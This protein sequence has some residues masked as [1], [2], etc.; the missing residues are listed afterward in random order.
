MIEERIIVRVAKDQFNVIVGHVL[1][2]EPLSRAEADRLAHSQTRSQKVMQVLDAPVVAA[3]APAPEPVP[4]DPAPQP[5]PPPADPLKPAA[6]YGPHLP[7][8]TR[9][10]FGRLVAIPPVVK[11]GAE[12][13]AQMDRV[14]S[15]SVPSS[16][17][18][19]RPWDNDG[20]GSGFSWN[21]RRW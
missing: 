20:G 12:T 15:A 11:S 8:N 9:M 4:D 10:Q 18:E 13:M 14:N 5:S 7:P 19:G 6:I 2:A 17:F 3:A 16:L 21:G 1:N